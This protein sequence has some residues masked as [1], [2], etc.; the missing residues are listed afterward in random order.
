MRTLW[1]AARVASGVL[2]SNGS[3]VRARRADLAGAFVGTVG[4]RDG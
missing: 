2:D 1:L 4:L 3:A